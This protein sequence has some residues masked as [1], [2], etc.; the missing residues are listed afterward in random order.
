MSFAG[1]AL[2]LAL[3]G[4]ACSSA[5]QPTPIYVVQTP[6]PVVTQA[7]ATPTPEVTPLATFTPWP[8]GTPTPT[9]GPTPKHTAAPAPTVSAG[10]TS[11]AAFCTGAA[12]NQPTFVQTAQ[13]LKFAVYC[14]TVA[15]P[16]SL[17]NWSFDASK[18]PGWVKA[19]YKSGSATLELDE[20]AFC[21]TSPAACSPN[22]GSLGTASFGSLSGSLDSTSA[23]YAIYVSPGTKNAYQ[24]L[25]HNV[26]QATLVSIAAALKVIPKT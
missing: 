19:T 17:S 3:V 20:G 10:P 25:G 21:L 26:S 9:A 24:I 18:A 23:G 12:T 8:T 11:P 14:P 22:T 16:W 1:A 7:P 6:A 5:V 13:T 2:A 15:K 4:A